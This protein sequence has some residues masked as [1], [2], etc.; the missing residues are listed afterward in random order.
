[1]MPSFR[2]MMEMVGRSIRSPRE[3]AQEVLALG[4]PREAIGVIVG[5]VIILNVLVTEV[6]LMSMVM[7]L[8]QEAAI[9]AEMGGQPIYS[10]ILRVISF[11]ITIGAVFWIGR[12]MGG[13]GS[14][15]ETAI[16]LSWFQF[17]LA[18]TMVGMIVA[19]LILP[20]IAAILGLVTLLM[21]PWVFT[22]FIAALHG[23]QSLISVFFCV[24]VFSFIGLFLVSLLVSLFGGV[25]APGG[26]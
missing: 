24:V 6:A 2:Q 25:D 8:G 15:E 18:C 3:G 9:I 23:F 22:N 14:L 5:F 10:A 21:I 20:P 17:L 4:V 1:M 11:V 7:A 12:A 13:T 26:A 19:T 16:L